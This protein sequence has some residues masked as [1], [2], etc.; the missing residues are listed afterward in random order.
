MR[1]HLDQSAQACVDTCNVCSY[2]CGNC[3][4]RMTGIT[5]SAAP[6]PVVNVLQHAPK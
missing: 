3:F 2:A 6:R 5:V 4:S 1:H